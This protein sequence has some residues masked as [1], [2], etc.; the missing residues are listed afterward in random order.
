MGISEL[1]CGISHLQIA[2]DEE[3]YLLLLN[4]P[5]KQ[6]LR[7]P[8]VFVG[9]FYHPMSTLIPATFNE[10]GY[11][12]GHGIIHDYF[13][14]V[15]NTWGVPGEHDQIPE[16]NDSISPIVNCRGLYFETGGSFKMKYHP[17]VFPIKKCILDHILKTYPHGNEERLQRSF[18]SYLEALEH[19]CPQLQPETREKLTY[20]EVLGNTALFNQVQMNIPFLR[21]ISLEVL[22]EFYTEI[23]IV[24][25]VISFMD[26]MNIDLIPLMYGARNASMY[27]EFYEVCKKEAQQIV[28]KARRELEG[29]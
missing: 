22:K 4:G 26:S 9:E 23:N 1:A 28:D 3:F 16:D 18:S 5:R 7:R 27:L 14:E 19:T 8:G 10:D 21:N 12:R 17:A 13:V 6:F 11:L 25:R 2:Y 29:E 15:I 20:K 24:C